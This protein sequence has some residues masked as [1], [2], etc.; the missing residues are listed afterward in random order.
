MYTE[1]LSG[2]KRWNKNNIV[3]WK[4]GSKQGGWGGDIR[5]VLGG[6]YQNCIKTFLY[7][8]PDHHLNLIYCFPSFII[9]V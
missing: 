1:Y 2:G 9:F 7:I 8:F 3:R 6:G 5:E 4:S